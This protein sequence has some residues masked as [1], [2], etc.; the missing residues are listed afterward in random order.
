MILTFFALQSEC[1][2]LAQPH[3]KK[4]LFLVHL[5]FLAGK[6]FKYPIRIKELFFVDLGFTIHSIIPY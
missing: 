2:H 4:M 6:A 1:A 5:F 3:E